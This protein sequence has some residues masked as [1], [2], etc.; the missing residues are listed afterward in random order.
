MPRDI[1]QTETQALV[2]I[3]VHSVSFLVVVQAFAVSARMESLATFKV[4]PHKMSVANVT[5]ES[6]HRHPD[7]EFVSSARQ[8]RTVY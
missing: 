1:S 7:C 5:L 3:Y 2:V 8:I 6:L 4:D